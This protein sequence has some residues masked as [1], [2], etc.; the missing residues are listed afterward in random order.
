MLVGFLFSHI[1]KKWDLVKAWNSQN[2]FLL[3]S[4][5][6]FLVEG[7]Q[8]NWSLVFLTLSL[9]HLAGVAISFNILY[10]NFILKERAAQRQGLLMQHVPVLKHPHLKYSKIPCISGEMVSVGTF[11][12]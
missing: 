7:G 9:C 12:T 5:I 2:L 8:K 1:G 10:M 6:I 4:L 11:K 3:Q